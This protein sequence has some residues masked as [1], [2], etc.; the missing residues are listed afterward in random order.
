MQ[1]GLFKRQHD[2]SFE[3]NLIDCHFSRSSV[4]AFEKLVQRRNSSCVTLGSNRH[5]QCEDEVTIGHL[6]HVIKSLIMT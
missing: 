4:S 5:A 1:I 2:F 6:D 3:V